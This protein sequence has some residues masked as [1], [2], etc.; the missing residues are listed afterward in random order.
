MLNAMPLGLF[1]QLIWS[2]VVLCLVGIWVQG[3]AVQGMRSFC[4]FLQTRLV[5]FVT[6]ILTML[7]LLLLFLLEQ[8][9]SC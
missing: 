3:Q 6:F 2:K 1:L 8:P 9:T 4:L 5:T 7:A